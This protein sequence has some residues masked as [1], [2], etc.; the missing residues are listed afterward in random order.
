LPC[1][2]LYRPRLR[3]FWFLFF[4]NCRFSLGWF[5]VQSFRGVIAVVVVVG[6]HCRRE[7]ATRRAV[8]FG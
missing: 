1:R 3:W 2:F 7:T 8:P 6:V 5:L 4:H